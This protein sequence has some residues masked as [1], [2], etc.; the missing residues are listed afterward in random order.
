[1]AKHQ[2]SK[3]F[4]CAQKSE[5]FLTYPKEVLTKN[6]EERV[7]EEKGQY[8]KYTYIDP[9]TGSFVQ[10]SCPWNLVTGDG[11]FTDYYDAYGV[12]TTSGG[13]VCGRS[14]SDCQDRF[15]DYAD[16]PTRAFPGVGRTR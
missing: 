11:D 15:G 13:D 10:G 16:L 14:L 1:M 12:A 7:L 6:Q 9:N 8:I 4:E 3:I 5:G 2:K